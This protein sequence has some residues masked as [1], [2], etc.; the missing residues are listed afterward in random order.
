M[1]GLSVR[2]IK[3]IL[4]KAGI[5]YSDCC[6]KKDLAKRLAEVRAKA[7]KSSSMREDD[8]KPSPSTGRSSSDRNLGGGRGASTRKRPSS[9][10]GGS[11]TTRGHGDMKDVGALIRRINGTKD[12]YSILGVGR[13]ASDVELKKSYRKLALKLHPDKCNQEGSEDAFKKVGSAY[14]CLSDPDKRKRYDLL[15]DDSENG[16]AG[17][18]GGGNPDVDEVL[19]QFFG[20]GMNGGGM[21]G[22]PGVRFHFG[23]PGMFF[24]N[25]GGRQQQ[26]GGDGNARGVGGGLGALAPFMPF[27]LMMLVQAAPALLGLLSRG[28]LFLPMILLLPSH[29]RMHALL[30]VFVMMFI[31]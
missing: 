5:D 17:G 15:G 23:G 3:E 1:E 22:G 28:F 25:M 30:L 11:S 14:H 9:T 8:P 27:I 20:G 4:D 31:I 26:Q 10:A 21:H 7:R 2:Q 6:E 24:Q 29:L 16:A 18:F 19:R 12:Y 13:D